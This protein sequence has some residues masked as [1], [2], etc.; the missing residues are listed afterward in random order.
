MKITDSPTKYMSA[1]TAEK[2]DIKVLSPPKTNKQKKAIFPRR[3]TWTGVRG[4]FYEH[5]TS[6]ESGYNYH[7]DKQTIGNMSLF[8]NI[9][10]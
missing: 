5:N 8:S 2:F 3:S 4:V 1:L 10:V 7:F 9:L 6:F